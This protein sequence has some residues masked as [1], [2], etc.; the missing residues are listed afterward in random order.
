MTGEVSQARRRNKLSGLISLANLPILWVS[1]KAKYGTTRGSHLAPA[2]LY[3]IIAITPKPC[4]SSVGLERRIVDP[5]VKGSTP[6]GRTDRPKWA[7]FQL[8]HLS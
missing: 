8:A 3:T 7:S 6:F 1:E 5:E 4:C 2:R